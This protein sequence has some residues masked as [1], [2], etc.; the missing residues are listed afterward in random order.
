MSCCKGPG[1]ASPLDAFHNGPREELL[2]VVC[3]IHRTYTGCTEDELH[4]SGWN[5][6]SSCYDKP[7]FKRD[8]LVCPSLH[9]SR[10]FVIDVG[11]EPRKP[12]LFKMVLK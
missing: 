12:K 9:T 10:V 2:Y 4:H 8:L 7:E 5:V 3:V 1:Y 6:C 11:S